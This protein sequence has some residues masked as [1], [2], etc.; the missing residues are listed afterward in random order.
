MLV[1]FAALEMPS[2]A[3]K[4]LYWI[5]SE[6]Q[7]NT[8]RIWFCRLFAI[9]VFVCFFSDLAT[10]LTNHRPKWAARIVFRVEMNVLHARHKWLL[11]RIFAISL[12]PHFISI[13]LYRIALGFYSEFYCDFGFSH[14]NQCPHSLSLSLSDG[15][16]KTRQHDQY[17]LINFIVRI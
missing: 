15:R 12:T 17:V 6:H 7:Q 1:N 2:G 14:I 10:V 13:W 11:T 16:M 4:F 8:R 3:M 9:F 5:L